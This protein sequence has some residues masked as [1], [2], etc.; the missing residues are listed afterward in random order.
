M[1][2]LSVFELVAEKSS[3]EIELQFSILDSQLQNRDEKFSKNPRTGSSKVYSLT[4]N[5][6]KR[7]VITL[8][9]SF[10]VNTYSPK[11]YLFCQ[12]IAEINAKVI[13][14]DEA[15]SCWWT[16]NEIRYLQGTPEPIVCKLF[17]DL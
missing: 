7:L 10:S 17:F 4:K 15:I 3:I 14:G 1:T 8:K 11:Y 9:L 5:S 6:I 2:I 12:L 13:F 16:S